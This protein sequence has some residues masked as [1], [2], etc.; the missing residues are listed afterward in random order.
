MR[1]QGAVIREQ[2]QTFAVVVVK[3]HVVQNRAEATDAIQSF[4]SVFGMPVVLMAQDGRGSPTFY[5]RK[6][7][8]R[9]MSGVP[10]HAIPWRDYSIN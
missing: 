10:L 8:A 4:T 9:F 1:V 6:D 5:G 2:G 3:P 7:I